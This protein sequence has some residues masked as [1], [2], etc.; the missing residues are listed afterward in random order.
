MDRMGEV[1]IKVE[2][3]LSTAM[4]RVHTVQVMSLSILTVLVLDWWVIRSMAKSLMEASSIVGCKVGKQFA[5]LD[6]SC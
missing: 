5:N 2:V 6:K 1:G 4:E 3:Q